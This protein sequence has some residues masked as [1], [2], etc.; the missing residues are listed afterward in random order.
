[1]EMP[2][3]GESLRIGRRLLIPTA[4]LREMLTGM[5]EAP[6][7]PPPTE[8]ALQPTPTLDE[9]IIEALAEAVARGIERAKQR[10]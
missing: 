1:M 7:A 5:T 6:A 4:R 9:M 3:S 8:P 2:Q 10:D